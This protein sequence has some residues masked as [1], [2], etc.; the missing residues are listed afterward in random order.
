MYIQS[1]KHSLTIQL[2]L[3]ATVLQPFSNF[4]TSIP[5]SV[6]YFL[7]LWDSLFPVEL[8]FIFFNNTIHIIGLRRNWKET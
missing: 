3:H 7:F 4:K 1:L 6:V 8:F 2:F 5:I